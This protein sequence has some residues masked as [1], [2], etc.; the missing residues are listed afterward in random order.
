MLTYNE[1]MRM[2]LSLERSIKGAEAEY[3]RGGSIDQKDYAEHCKRL[4]KAYIIEHR[5]VAKRDGE[6]SMR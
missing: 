2:I 1:T 3:E 4:L 5:K 6:Y